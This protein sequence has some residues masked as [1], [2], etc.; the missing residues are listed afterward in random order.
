MAAAETGLAV[1]AGLER[2]S[3]VDFRRSQRY[4]LGKPWEARVVETQAVRLVSMAVVGDVDYSSKEDG[5]MVPFFSVRQHSVLVGQ[6]VSTYQR[7]QLLHIEPQCQ[8]PVV[9]QDQPQGFLAVEGTL[10]GHAWSR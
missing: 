4:R 2:D 7:F 6:L 3:Q 10:V 1:R 9:G 8:I 5:R